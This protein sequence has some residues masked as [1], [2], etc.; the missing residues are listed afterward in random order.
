MKTGGEG[1]QVV[2]D[3]GAEGG[4]DGGGAGAFVLAEFGEEVGAEGDGEA[5]RAAEVAEAVFV[6]G[7]DEAEEE[8]DG[9]VVQVAVADLLD[10]FLRGGFV[11]GFDDLA[12]GGGALRDGEGVV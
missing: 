5:G 9:D 2:F 3:G 7:V 6:G 10:D 4:V 1:V 12:G 11:E 8:A